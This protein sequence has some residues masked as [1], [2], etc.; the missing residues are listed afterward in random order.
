MEFTVKNFFRKCEQIHSFLQTCLHL[1]KKS[2]MKTSF[3]YSVS[4]FLQR[5]WTI[6]SDEIGSFCYEDLDTV[7]KW[8]SYYFFDIYSF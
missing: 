5:L 2:L 7:Y 4:S 6:N 1:L 8:D 3:S